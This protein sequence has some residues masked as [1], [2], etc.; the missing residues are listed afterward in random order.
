MAV[1]LHPVRAGIPVP[2]IA[3][4]RE[5]ETRTLAQ[6]RAIVDRIIAAYHDARR[7]ASRR[8]QRSMFGSVW[9]ENGFAGGQAD[10]VRALEDRSAER[11]HDI[12]R[13]FL[14]SE[15]AHGIAMG[16]AEA[17]TVG[18]NPDLARQY[19]LMWLDQLVG[20][21]HASGALPAINPEDNFA[22][23]ERALEIDVDDVAAAI[24]HALGVTLDFPDAIGVFGAELRGRPFPV[25]AFQHL[26]VALSVRAWT[27]SDGGGHVVE[28]GGGFGDLAFWTTR[29][30]PCRYTIYDLPFV[31]AAQAY[32]LS[33]ALPGHPLRLA[34]EPPA[35]D[36]EIAL[37]P[38]WRLLDD[39]PP[40]ADVVVNQNSLVEIPRDTARA[41]LT[42]MRGFLKGPFLS[43]NH[44]SWQR[45][46]DTVDRT[47]VADSIA[48]VGGYTR[49]SRGPFPL[50]VG[51]VQ[52]IYAPSGATLRTGTSPEIEAASASARTPPL[53]RLKRLLTRP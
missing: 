45:V 31:N 42:A 2:R 43:I 21:A 36:G 38:A 29:L 4:S 23:W 20:L 15:A 26:L 49:L 5:H 34:G 18:G 32:F 12:L 7:S 37:L 16:R 48:A 50:R 52:E 33:R 19:G 6:D 3:F 24:E 22:A 17:E 8:V 28:I 40:A 51:Y 25:I 14:V 9:S 13:R 39:A 30:L 27:A 46:A 41:Y 47:S 1:L 11:T 10:L 53:E 44:E 35:G